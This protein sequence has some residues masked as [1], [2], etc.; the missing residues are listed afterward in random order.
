MI[1]RRTVLL[2]AAVG[3]FARKTTARASTPVAGFPYFGGIAKLDEVPAGW[4]VG[5]IRVRLEPGQVWDFVYPGPVAVYVDSGEMTI[6]NERLGR[7]TMGDNQ[8][9]GSTGPGESFHGA[10]SNQIV[11][12]SGVSAR[13]GNLGPLTNNGRETL[14][15]I[16][17]NA[18]PPVVHSDNG[19]SSESG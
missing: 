14:V 11:P 10:P 15:V 9:G 13:D 3:W 1:R 2:S 18:V 6:A 17:L 8:G 16:I 7:F 4:G 12:G 19:D 5:V